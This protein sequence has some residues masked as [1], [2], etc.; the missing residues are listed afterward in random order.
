MCLLISIAKNKIT[1]EVCRLKICHHTDF[2]II[3]KEKDNWKN[4]FNYQVP[5]YFKI[6]K[7]EQAI[8]VL[9]F[10]FQLALFSFII[11]KSEYDVI[12]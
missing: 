2:G 11:S 1:E 5:L 12:C 3:R 4:K 6:I 10:S 8:I 7:R 9:I